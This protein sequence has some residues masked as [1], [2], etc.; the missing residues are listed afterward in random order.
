MLFYYDANSRVNVSWP[1]E[2]IKYH[3]SRRNRKRQRETEWDKKPSFPR[4]LLWCWC[5]LIII[6]I[7]VVVGSVGGDSG[8]TREHSTTRIQRGKMR[9]TILLL[10]CRALRG[11]PQ[12]ARPFR[13]VREIFLFPRPSQRFP[14]E[15]FSSCTRH[16]NNCIPKRRCIEYMMMTIDKFN[17]PY[18]HRTLNTINVII[19]F[20]FQL[21]ILNTFWVNEIY[22]QTVVFSV[23]YWKY[24]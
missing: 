5:W 22:D 12:A 19:W 2:G 15:H 24:F 10:S 23:I 9:W 8:G 4:L 18:F 20:L 17:G 21:F 7:V 16:R 13:W 3:A 6:I 14:R 11:I 1:V